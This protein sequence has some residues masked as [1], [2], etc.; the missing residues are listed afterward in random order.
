MPRDEFFAINTSQQPWE[1][2]YNEKL[3][4]A[5]LRKDLY[6]DPESGA[7]VRLV[8]YPAGLVNPFQRKVLF[9]PV[10]HVPQPLGRDATAFPIARARGAHGKPRDLNT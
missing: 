7:E 10:D 6:T 3:G 5:I 2:R 4:K 8:R 9:E 1:E